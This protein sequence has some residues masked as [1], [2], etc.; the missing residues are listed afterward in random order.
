MVEIMTVSFRYYQRPT[1]NVKHRADDITQ[2]N[3]EMKPNIVIS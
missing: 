3:V 1:L 2:R